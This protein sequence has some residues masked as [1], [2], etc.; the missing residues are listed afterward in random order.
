MTTLHDLDGTQWKGHCELWLDPLGNTAS[1]C[2]CQLRIGPGRLDYTWAHEGTA[3]EGQIVLTPEGA[4]FTDTFHSSSTMACR[5]AA[6]PL[7][8]VDVTGSYS[9]P[10]MGDWGWRIMVAQRPSEGDAPGELIVQMIN[11]AP[12]GEEGRAVR[13]TCNRW[14]GP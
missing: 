2:E 13:M 9:A 7:A 12:W 5:A 1:E 6:Q 3:H 14:I 11:I 10:G 4:E 8:L